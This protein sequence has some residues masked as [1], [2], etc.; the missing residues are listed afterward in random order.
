MK[1]LRLIRAHHLLIIAGIMYSLRFFMLEPILDMYGYSLVSTPFEFNLMVFSV[2]LI[3]GAA[4]IINNYF[5]RK[6][7]L[8]NRP[9]AVIVGTSVNR[10][11]AIILHSVLSFFG[12]IIGF[13]LCALAGHFWYGI[14]FIF[15]SVLFYLYSGYFKRRLLIGNIIISLLIAGITFLPW[16]TEYVFA[17]SH[18]TAAFPT[19]IYHHL[20]ILSLGFSTAAFLLNMAR[21][22]IKDIIDFRGDYQSGS[23]TLPIVYGKKISRRIG[24][25]ILT[26]SGIFIIAS[27]FLYLRNI[28]AIQHNILSVIYLSILLVVPLFF[29]ALSIHNAN[30]RRQLK[31]II[32]M[33]QLLM[34]LG[35]LFSLVIFLNITIS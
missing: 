29:L 6:P 24:S 8:M 11:L 33:V 25:L 35:V 30:K 28:L 2:L 12:V 1:Y 17:K 26:L 19:K 27:W 10:R 20:M 34:L 18:Y 5:D 23:K 3:T 21:E 14:S 16:L 32:S 4:S 13:Y 7:D 9:N 31:R 22:I 15:I